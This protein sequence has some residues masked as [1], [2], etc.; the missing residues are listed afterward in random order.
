MYMYA[1]AV[2]A[3]PWSRVHKIASH[4]LLGCSAGTWLEMKGWRG[5]GGEAE[6]LQTGEN[7][8]RF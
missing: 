1:H 8:S 6:V 3:V 2:P 5:G 4:T 7:V